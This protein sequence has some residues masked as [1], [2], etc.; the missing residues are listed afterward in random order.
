MKPLQLHQVHRLSPAIQAAA[1]EM[2]TRLQ[3]PRT[4]SRLALASQE[5]HTLQSWPVDLLV[6]PTILTTTPAWLS[7]CPSLPSISSIGPTICICEHLSMAKSGEKNT[8]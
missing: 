2:D 6:T 3:I 7:P 4:K 8:I 5:L 1:S